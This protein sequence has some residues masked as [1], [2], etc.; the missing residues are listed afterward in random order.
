MRL[1]D[2]V[3]IEVVG[4]VGGWSGPC[5][6]RLPAVWWPWAVLWPGCI[7]ACLRRLQRI[8]PQGRGW[9]RGLLAF[10]C[11]PDGGGAVL[12]LLLWQ[13]LTTASS[14]PTTDS[15]C[16]VHCCQGECVQANEA[17]VVLDSPCVL[18]T[19][20]SI[21]LVGPS[22]CNDSLLLRPK[23][24][25]HGR[26]PPESPHYSTGVQIVN[27]TLSSESVLSDSTGLFNPVLSVSAN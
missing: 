14:A 15:C 11:S 16:T 20:G 1:Q 12:A 22:P 23:R 27:C 21:R 5:Q 10:S 9:T 24:W 6:R 8:T 17:L 3:P 25:V 13:A 18:P 19:A 7:P 2:H 26:M 4:G